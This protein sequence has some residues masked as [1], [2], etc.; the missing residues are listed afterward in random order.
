MVGRIGE[1]VN[2]SEI[3]PDLAFEKSVNF[4]ELNTV[5]KTFNVSAKVSLFYLELSCAGPF[6]EE[7][8]I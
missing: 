8:V 3:V 5:K 7:T 6:R 2:I 4:F 1:F